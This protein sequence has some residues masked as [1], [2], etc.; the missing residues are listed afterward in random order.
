MLYKIS[1]L[2]HAVLAVT[3]Q[4]IIELSDRRLATKTKAAMLDWAPILLGL[5]LFILLSPGLLFQLP[6]NSRH[7]EFGS[8]ATN[9]KAILIHTL[10]FFVIFS[11]LILAVGV[12]IYTG[13]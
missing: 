1:K 7:I 3:V 11:I 2:Q 9:G 6:G 5:L 8:L 4:Y 13:H 12:H 10:L